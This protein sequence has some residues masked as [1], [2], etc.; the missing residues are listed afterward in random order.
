MVKRKESRAVNCT[1]KLCML[2]ISRYVTGYRHRIRNQ[3]E[4]I[5]YKKEAYRRLLQSRKLEDEV[6]YKEADLVMM[7]SKG[8]EKTALVVICAIFKGRLYRDRKNRFQY[9]NRV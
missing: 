6:E 4:S 8:T 2:R 3:K 7:L 9:L 5:E 1:G